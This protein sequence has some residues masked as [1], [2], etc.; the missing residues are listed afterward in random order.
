MRLCA[1]LIKHANFIDDMSESNIPYAQ[2][3]LEFSIDILQD[4]VSTS[5][6]INYDN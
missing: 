3:A 5:K 2:Q 1:S 4:Q 6:V